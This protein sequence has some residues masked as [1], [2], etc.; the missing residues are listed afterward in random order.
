[1]LTLTDTQ[2]RILSVIATT[3]AVCMYVSYIPQIQMN[4]SGQ[5]GTWLQPL[6]AAVNCTLWV[7]YALGKKNRDIPVAL[8]NAPGIILGLITCITSF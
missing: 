5:K 2:V 8:A 7:V 4:L 6:A 3:A 1:M